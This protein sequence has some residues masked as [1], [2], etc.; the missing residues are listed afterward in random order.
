MSCLACARSLKEGSSRGV[1]KATRNTNRSDSDGMRSDMY[2]AEN[3]GRGVELCIPLLTRAL[4]Q[5]PVTA[6]GTSS[7]SD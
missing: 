1:M 2:V 6:Y 3:K 5:G 4:G 7:N